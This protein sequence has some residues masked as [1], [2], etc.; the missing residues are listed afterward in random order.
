MKKNKYQSLFRMQPVVECLEKKIKAIN[1]LK[2]KDLKV[3]VF[4]LKKLE[5]EQC[6]N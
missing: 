4:H 6:P 5:K 1:T 3:E 2:K